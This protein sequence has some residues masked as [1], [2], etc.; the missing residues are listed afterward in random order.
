LVVGGG[1][2][3]TARI[4]IAKAIKRGYFGFVISGLTLT[5]LT[6]LYQIFARG[7]AF[8]MA[9]GWFHGKLTLVLVLIVASVVFGAQVK[10]AVDGRTVKAGTVGMIHGLASATLVLVAFLTLVGRA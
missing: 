6:G 3:E 7:M 10:A 5:L 9:Q 8:Y 2:P 1:L 4:E